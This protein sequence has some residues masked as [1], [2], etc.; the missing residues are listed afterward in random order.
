MA[1]LKIGTFGESQ[2][3]RS[4]GTNYLEDGV[5]GVKTVFN[6]NQLEYPYLYVESENL[7]I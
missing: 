6:D 2:G 3:S 1:H 5:E 7:R 4:Y